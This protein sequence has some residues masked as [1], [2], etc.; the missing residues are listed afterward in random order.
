[1]KSL[2]ETRSEKEPPKSICLRCFKSKASC[3]KEG[4]VIKAQIIVIAAMGTWAAVLV[5]KCDR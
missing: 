1:M 2:T 3:L 4:T 5:S